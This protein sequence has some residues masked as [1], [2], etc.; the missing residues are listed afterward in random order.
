MPDGTHTIIIEVLLTLLGF[1]VGV[2][3]TY[4]SMN[5]RFVLLA[6]CNDHRKSCY[7]LGKAEDTASN[8]RA[9]M[10]EERIRGLEEAIERLW[11]CSQNNNSAIVAIAVKLG[12]T[13]PG[14]RN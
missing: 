9:K 5:A 11:K 1:I 13:L 10:M 4:L 7:A 6:Q 8:D 14:D 2:F 3:T 12:V